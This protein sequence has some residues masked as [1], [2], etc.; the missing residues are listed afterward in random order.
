MEQRRTWIVGLLLFVVTLA[1]YWPATH[2]PFVSYDDQL[3]VYENPQVIKGLSWPGF[4]WACTSIVCDNWLPLTQLSHMADCSLFHLFAG[5]HHLTSILL[6]AVNTVLLWSLLK[7]LTISFWPSTL[8]AALFAWHPL[9]V[10]SVAWI[11]ERNNV[12]SMFFFIVTLSAYLSYV[13]NPRPAWYVLALALFALGLMAKP[14]LVTL[15]CLLLLLDYWPL[16]R[17]SP[18]QSIGELASQKESR[19]LLWEKIPFLAL[20]LADCVITYIVQKQS[21]AIRS[22]TECPLD[23]RLWNIPVAYV[24]YVAKT[25][26]P[27]KL[28]VLYVFPD[29]APIVTAT[30]SLIWLVL[31]TILGWRLKAR[32]PWFFTGWFWFLGTLVPVIGLIQSGDHAMADRYAY[33]PFVGLFFVIAFGLEAGLLVKPAL[34]TVIIATTAIFI[35]VCLVL[36]RQQLMSWQD[37]VALF[38]QAVAVNPENADAQNLLGRALSG[39]GRSAEAIEHFTDAVHLHPKN[40]SLQYDLGRELIATGEFAKAESHLAVAAEQMPNDPVLGNAYGVALMNNGKPEEAARTFSRTIE[41]QPGYSKP[42]FNLGKMQFAA[43]QNQPA[44]K[45]FTSALQLESDWPEALEALARTYA[46][47]GDWTNAVQSATFALQS[48]QAHFKPALAG[49]IT[50]ELNSYQKGMLPSTPSKP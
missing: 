18:S 35:G 21:G 23:I 37:S 30:L 24:T 2:F 27:A 28:C 22:L 17:I 7:R 40:A 1:I 43:G 6:H 44:I 11:A 41:L 16:R 10:E 47:V 15:P 46:T 50:V 4:V 42:Y 19:R 32:L 31:V 3:Y 20:A 34:R 8:V 33:L 9:N 49:Q 38:T 36:T 5:G 45:N 12:L 39:R 29:K 25:F 26:F 48:A 13:K 14:M